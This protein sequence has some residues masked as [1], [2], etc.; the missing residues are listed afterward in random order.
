MKLD[1]TGTK[2]HKLHKNSDLCEQKTAA[3]QYV[4]AG[5]R[6]ISVIFSVFMLNVCDLF[7]KFVQF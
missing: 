7:D 4:F 3:Y 6:D 1:L 5:S 2:H